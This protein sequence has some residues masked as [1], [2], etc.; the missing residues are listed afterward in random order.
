MSRPFS[1][2]RVRQSRAARSHRRFVPLVGP[3]EGRVLLSGNPPTGLTATAVSPTQINLTW[4]NQASSIY[5]TYVA[6]S[7]NDVSWTTI[8]SIYG[9]PTSYTATGPFNGSTTYYYEVWNY[10][11]TGSDTADSSVASVT[12]PAYP[13]PPTLNSAT[14]LSNTS[15]GLSWTAATA[16]TGYL[17][18]RSTNGG[19]T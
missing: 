10:L 9:A 12:T 13:N 6:Q 2:R 15:I 17:V 7:T 4:T 16:A 5:Y 1:A 3:L 19:S 8:A 14:P 18:E 11:T